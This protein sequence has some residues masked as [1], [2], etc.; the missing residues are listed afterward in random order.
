MLGSAPD[1]YSTGRLKRKK[2]HNYFSRLQRGACSFGA[3]MRQ[4]KSSLKQALAVID[5]ESEIFMT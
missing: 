2:L 3:L 5:V 1:Y 4:P